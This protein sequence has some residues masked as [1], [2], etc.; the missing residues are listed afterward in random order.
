MTVHIITVQT[1]EV[2]LLVNHQ[3]IMDG[4]AA[5]D[6]A[7]L[8]TQTGGRLA[9]AL[10][11]TPKLIHA[12]PADPEW[13]WPDLI[14]TLKISPSEAAPASVLCSQCGSPLLGGMCR[15]AT[16]PYS[17]WPQQVTAE[18]I[19][20]LTADAIVAKYGLIRAEIHSDDYVFEASFFA[21]NWFIGAA[22]SCIQTLIAEDW[23]HCEEA[24]AVARSAD[25]DWRVAQVFDYIHAHNKSDCDPVGFEC[26]INATDAM[27]WLRQQRY[28]L[29]C[30]LRCDERDIRIVE[31]QKPEVAGMYDWIGPLG[32]ACTI[33]LES[34]DH[35]AV[36]AVETLGL[37]EERDPVTPLYE[38]FWDS[39]AFPAAT[40][41]APQIVGA[42]L[43]CADL[44]YDLEDI[45]EIAALNR[46]ETWRSADFGDYHTVERIR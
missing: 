23:G 34:P 43:F 1:G 19:K 39:D 30:R 29:W 16:C 20:N 24:D 9:I 25:N 42:D 44:G 40:S 13:E 38:C 6:S 14:K 33:S 22:D 5:D 8:V 41:E 21:Q 7:R 32:N 37:D 18:D 35:A 10:N 27:R 26:T 45:R 12:S 11:T 4:D 36:N 17:D 15:D 28:G 3:L 46:G 2:A 31:A